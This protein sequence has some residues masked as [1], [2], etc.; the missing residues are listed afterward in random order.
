[1][2]SFA[3]KGLKMLYTEDAAMGVPSMAARQA[4]EDAGILG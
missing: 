4:P 3:H 2:R 1:M